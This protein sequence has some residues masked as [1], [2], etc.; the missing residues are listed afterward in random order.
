MKGVKRVRRLAWEN[1]DSAVLL[2]LRLVL[3]YLLKHEKT[4]VIDSIDAYNE[5]ILNRTGR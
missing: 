2:I 3:A 4:I 5:I 1:L